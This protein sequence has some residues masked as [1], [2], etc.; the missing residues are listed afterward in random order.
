MSDPE[1]QTAD[2]NEFDISFGTHVIIGGY[3]TRL[4]PSVWHRRQDT[5]AGTSAT[6]LPSWT[7]GIV[8]KVAAYAVRIRSEMFSRWET[9]RSGSLRGRLIMRQ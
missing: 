9:I 5:D 3:A 8:P 7:L 4:P 1:P 2:G 6:C